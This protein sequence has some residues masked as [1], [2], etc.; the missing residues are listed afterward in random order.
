MKTSLTLAAAAVIA[1]S[2]VAQTTARTN[3]RQIWD[4]STEYTSRLNVGG[5]TGFLSQAFPFGAI[6][7]AKTLTYAQYVVQDFDQSTV[8]PWNF[9]YCGLDPQGSGNPDYV[10]ATAISTNNALAAGTGVGAWIITHTP[11]ATTPVNLN[12]SSDRLI[13]AW[14]FTV[15]TNWTTDGLSI[16]MSEGDQTGLPNSANTPL[17]YTFNTQNFQCEMNRVEG[18]A[19]VPSNEY[20]QSSGPNNT[21]QDDSRAWRLVIGFDEVT[22]NGGID[23]PTY[24]GI[25][26]NPNFGYGGLDPDFNDIAAQQT[27]REDNFAWRVNAGIS[28][29]GNFAFLLSSMAMFENAIP[30]PFGDLYLNPAGDVLFSGLGAQAFPTPLDAQGIATFT[31]AAP[32]A[33]RP[34][35]ASIP[36]WSAQALVFDTTNLTAE[37]STVHTMRPWFDPKLTNQAGWTQAVADSTTPHKIARPTQP[38]IQLFVRNDGPGILEIDEMR[39]TTKL[40]TFRVNERTAVREFTSPAGTEWVVRGLHAKQTTFVYLW[41]Y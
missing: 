13:F 23:N 39:G 12:F 18:T 19:I 31:L 25:C 14:Q 29:S 37:L 20:G 9:V 33:L 16:H 2:A 26:A 40:R 27:K 3:E 36:S 22:L 21:F 24:N 17:C 15:A 35:L 6:A 41:N 32:A 11:L 7:G 34:L 4:G 28:N 30:T 1:A 5:A 10:G 38:P 8:E